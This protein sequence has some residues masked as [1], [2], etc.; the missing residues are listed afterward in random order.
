[1]DKVYVIAST[2][3]DTGKGWLTASIASLVK[4]YPIKIDPALNALYIP[5][6]V[7]NIDAGLVSTDTPTYRELGLDIGQKAVIRGGDIIYAYL[8][9][10]RKAIDKFDPHTEK[11]KTFADVS[12]FL[13]MRLEDLTEDEDNAPVIEMGG[14]VYDDNLQYLAD[15][16]RRFTNDNKADLDIVL[17]SYLTNSDDE[18]HAIKVNEV[19]KGVRRVAEVYWREPSWVFVR[20]RT[21][22]ELSSDEVAHHIQKI[23][24]RTHMPLERILFE[25]EF[26][27][28]TNLKNYI[29]SLNL[30]R[31]PQHAPT[32]RIILE[33][34]VDN[35]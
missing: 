5:R 22:W 31:L 4:G 15:G 3:A 30:F 26:E 10:I 14:S 23:A 1:M 29:G 12:K 13:A 27:T 7:K 8:Q 35:T 19:V 21:K 11:R 32:T 34:V 24:D 9:S 16:V 2:L 18:N 17:L 28:A 6:D 20:N 33:V 25:P